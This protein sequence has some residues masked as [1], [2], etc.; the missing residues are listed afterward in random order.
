MR[1][2]S[3]KGFHS[4]WNLGSPGGW[5]Y[6]RMTQE[7]GKIMWEK[8]VDLSGL[9]LDLDFDYPLLDPTTGFMNA[10]LDLHRRNFHRREAH[11]AIVAEEETLEAVV[12]NKNIVIRLNRLPGVT[13]SLAAPHYLEISGDDVTFNGK[14][15]T[16]V[17]VDFNNDVLVNLSRSHDLSGLLL[18]VN[19]NI[20]M[21]PR[22]TGP[23][24]SKG[25]FELVQKELSS[26]LNPTTVKRTPWTRRF[27]PRSTEG[28]DGTVINDLIE[29]TRRRNNNLVLKPEEGYSGMGVFAGWQESDWDSCIETALRKGDYIVQQKVPLSLWA[30]EQPW[31]DP[32]AKTLEL[33]T[34]QTDFR[35]LI[36]HR[37][38]TGFV[39]RFGGVPTNVGSGGG[40]QS[41]ALLKSECSIK[42]AVDII[43][44]AI[45]DIGYN[46]MTELKERNDA[47]AV[48]YGL[49]YLLGPIMTALR[50][51]LLTM[52][53]VKE[54][55]IYA[56]NLWNDTVFLESLW[57]DGSLDH[58]ISVSQEERELA[59]A[60]PWE[61]S[62]ALIA[63]DGLFN[64]GAA[65]EPK[66]LET[67][68][69]NSVP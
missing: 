54:L 26:R 51:R 27:Y 62:P 7:L 52:K 55:Q 36:T 25:V 32:V 10:L 30:E 6:Q 33:K 22:G 4:E 47:L 9:N 53:Q 28:P 45:L 56:E 68:S 48:E 39:A 19:R 65:I 49:V 42:E 2:F 31:L 38:L 43:N 57:K 34:W 11:V 60:H 50:P 17:F 18:A 63:S 64:F 12:E 14:T 61:G 3:V 66:P 23:I 46:T 16:S 20:V 40:V 44:Q 1:S 35:C 59:E 67:I 13:A 5:D 8:V 24:N 37:G 29:W 21:N 41:I 69:G 58:F 15:V